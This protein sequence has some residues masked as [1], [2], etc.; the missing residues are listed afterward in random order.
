MSFLNE[1]PLIGPIL[2]WTLPFLIVLSIVVAIHELGH[3]MVGR[4]CG[5]K[6]QVYSIGF[7]K[8]LWSRT[9]RHGTKWQLALLP[10]GG[11]VKF[12]GDM[13]PASAGKV[14][15]EEIPPEER[16]HAF[17]NAPLWAR[18][19]TVL[20][21]PVANFL[22]SLVVFFGI[23]LYTGKAS[24]EPVIASIGDL[25]AEEIGL[26]P[27]DRVLEIEGVE[28]ETFT[29]VVR[30]LADGHGQTLSAT[31]LREDQ[32][33]QISI[34]Y[35][36][37]PQISDVLADGRALA[38]GMQPGDYLRVI[39]G[40]SVASV[41]DVMTVMAGIEPGK[42]IVVEVVREGVDKSFTLVPEIRMRRDHVTGEEK[43]L[44]TL[45]ISMRSVQGL[46]SIPEP[47]G[48]GEAAEAAVASVWRIIS[49][50]VVYIDQMLFHDATT[51][52]LS[53][54]IGIAKHSANAAQM[55]LPNLIQLI[56]FI[57][58]AIGLLNLFPIP[59]LDGGH[60]MFYLW[61]AIRG[62][63]TNAKVV[64]YGSMAGLSLLLLLMVFVTFNNDLGLGAW[65]SQD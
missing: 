51:D 39:D 27:G 23:A 63:P 25:N 45:G 52:H 35:Q 37:Y 18:T 46:R 38:R 2:M 19:L 4:W 9:D 12:L 50:T 1:I 31:V 7:G 3:L 13:D 20:A 40:Q 8:V 57:S 47:V 43:P 15:E 17:H 49:N 41:N 62:K 53:G 58:T 28:I 30:Q 21:G 42:E 60:L 54:P 29:D 44:P 34:L 24:D 64:E 26:Q 10:L 36:S 61:E 22:L 5:I 56:A 32:R 65:F 33:T 14:D 6:A 55:G 48:V 16:K 11:F 59:V